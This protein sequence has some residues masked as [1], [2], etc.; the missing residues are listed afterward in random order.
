MME[1]RVAFFEMSRT[2][3]TLFLMGTD[4]QFV[5]TNR[6]IGANWIDL[7]MVVQCRPGC[8][9]NEEHPQQNK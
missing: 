1:L 6:L 9:G 8:E 3:E 4:M 7:L 5:F 2:N